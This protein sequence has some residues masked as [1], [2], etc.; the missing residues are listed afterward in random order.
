MT[1]QNLEKKID[2]L[3]NAVVKHSILL[4][5]MDVNLEYHIKR[6]TQLEEWIKLQQEHLIMQHTTL[7]RS[8]EPIKYLITTAKII[9]WS[10]PLIT[11]I[12]YITKV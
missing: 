6:T 8:I 10:I 1:L 9:A 11:L 7:Q 2:K 5:R 4:E 3:D 12:Y